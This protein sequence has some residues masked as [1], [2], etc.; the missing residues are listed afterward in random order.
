MVKKIAKILAIL[1]VVFEGYFYLSW[2]TQGASNNSSVGVRKA[3]D[4]VESKQIE[5][6]E[7]KGQILQYVKGVK[8]KEQEIGELGKAI[9]QLD[10]EIEKMSGLIAQTQKNIQ[11][12][13]DKIKYYQ[14][15]IVEEEIAIK[16]QK[17]LIAQ[18]LSEIYELK[19]VSLL[20]VTLGTKKIS[21]FL[22]NKESIE[23]VQKS[24][25]ESIQ[26]VKERK[27]SLEKAKYELE[28]KKQEQNDLKALQEVQKISLIEKSSQKSFLLEN[29]KNE[30]GRFEK[31]LAE[32]KE[33]FNSI[34]K[35][36]KL[37]GGS[38]KLSFEDGLKY[39][40][41][42]EQK[43]GTRRAFILAILKQE[44]NWG[45]NTGT[46]IYLDALSGCVNNKKEQYGGNYE[47][48]LDLAQKRENTFLKII[49][50]L[51]LSETTL[52]SAC[53]RSYLGTGG[54]LGPAQFMPDTWLGYKE[55]AMSLK[56]SPV[57]PFD[58]QDAMLAMGI[59]LARAGANSKT[60]QAEWKAAMIYFA[61]GNWDNPNFSF[62]GDSV[63]NLAK[64]YQEEIDKVRVSGVK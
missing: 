45:Q 31:L 57:S 17:I 4:L 44:S 43:T 46:S 47:D 29:A 49:K 39:A 62:Y 60:E 52:V 13:D 15:L 5:L 21:D 30:K 8:F 6:D 23:Q 20:Q 14:D 32:A 58:V 59:K 37:I 48:A 41:F 2:L 61:G 35:E 54:A 50:E 9:K 40:E 25:N 42:V 11:D 33:K 34:R 36:I 22:N 55:E 63:I 10:E 53:P 24:I 1:F 28:I 64:A 51:N 12:T 19:D 3:S 26:I 38:E 56:G 27:A 7:V 16:Y 18:Y